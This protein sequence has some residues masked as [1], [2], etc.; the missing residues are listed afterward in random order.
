[1]ALKLFSTLVVV[2]VLALSLGNAQAATP[3][4]E[5]QQGDIT[6]ITGGIGE[7]ETKTLRASKPH[8]GLRVMN[9]D[10]TGHF[11]G[12]ARIKISDAKGVVL[13]DTIAG[14]IFYANLPDAHYT[15]E[16]IS[17]ERTKQQKIIVKRGTPVDVR[18][19]WEQE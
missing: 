15:L 14:P 11:S 19:S 4:A 12:T 13:L 17:G 10:K 16:S 3:L 18:F 7:V 9:A 5:Q 8:Y 6:Y 1:M 2:S